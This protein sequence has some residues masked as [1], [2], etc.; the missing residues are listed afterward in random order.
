MANQ[1]GLP[2]ML[3]HAMSSARQSLWGPAKRH[4]KT[5]GGYI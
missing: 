4:G 3:C 1:V 2:L 5:R